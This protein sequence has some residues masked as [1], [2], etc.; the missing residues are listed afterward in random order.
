[1][2]RDA[3]SLDFDRLVAIGGV[4]FSARIPVY[5]EVDALQKRV[6]AIYRQDPLLIR[7]L[8]ADPSLMNRV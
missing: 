7:M 3:I 5:M 6:L 4:G 2:P 8:M 1:L